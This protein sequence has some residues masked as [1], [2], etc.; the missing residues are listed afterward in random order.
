[1]NFA[2]A[3]AIPAAAFLYLTIGGSLTTNPSAV[4]VTLGL[5]A[6]W[7]AAIVALNTLRNRR[8]TGVGPLTR[9]V[10]VESVRDRAF[11]PSYVRDV[12]RP[13]EPW[14]ATSV[15]FA[16]LELLAVA[17]SI[18]FVILL[19]VVP[20]GLALAILLWLGRL[21]LGLF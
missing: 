9:H 3:L 1:M 2:L 10:V 12:S 7:L 16:P 13:L 21:I 20:I 19:I 14:R 18:P 8:E 5:G 4:G 6:L 17:W 11:T 15:L